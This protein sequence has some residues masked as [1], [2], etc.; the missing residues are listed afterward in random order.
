MAACL[1]TTTGTSGQLV[2]NYKIATISQAPITMGIGSIYIEDTATNVTY[3]ILS[4]D[5]IASS[6]CL[7]INPLPYTCYKFLWKGIKADDYKFVSL[8]LDND[9]FIIPESDFPRNVTTLIQNVNNLENDK[10][11]ITKYKKDYTLITNNLEDLETSIIVRIIGTELPMFK[12]RN[13]DNTGF[14]Y[15]RG[16]LISCNVLGYIDVNLCESIF[17]P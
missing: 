6:L 8:Y 9:I 10:F 14:I 7:T 1:I 2:I 17:L 3:T 4:G 12:I 5:I 13:A 16:E 15:L 11:K